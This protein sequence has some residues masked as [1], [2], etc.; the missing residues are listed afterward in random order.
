MAANQVVEESFASQES[1]EE[2]LEG[3]EYYDEEEDNDRPQNRVDGLENLRNATIES[4][5]KVT[6]KR[7]KSLA[8]AMAATDIS[9]NGALEQDENPQTKKKGGIKSKI[10]NAFKNLF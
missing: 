5:S 4:S 7:G 6:P 2:D 3:D 10:K 9:K 8:P 1:S